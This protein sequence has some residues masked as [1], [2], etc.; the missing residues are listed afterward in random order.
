MKRGDRSPP[1]MPGRQ[2]IVSARRTL[3]VASGG[4]AHLVQVSPVPTNRREIL[5]LTLHFAQRFAATAGK[6]VP[7]LSED[8][9]RFLLSRRWTVPELIWRVSRAVEHNDGSLV[10]AADL[11]GAGIDRV[12]GRRRRR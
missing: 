11:E 3:K 2:V 1:S 5:A 8:A 7:V 6:E 10:I 12:S 4:P 9:A